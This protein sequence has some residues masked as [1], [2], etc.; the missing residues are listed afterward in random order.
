MCFCMY[1]ACLSAKLRRA[2]TRAV[3][4]TTPRVRCFIK[5]DRLCHENTNHAQMNTRKETVHPGMK[6]KYISSHLQRYIKIVF[7]CESQRFGDMSCRE[8]CLLSDIIETRWHSA[9]AAQSA[10][11]KNLLFSRNHDPVTQDDPQTAL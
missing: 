6:N 8:V 4:N 3:K 2:D 10:P 1:S 5:H 7:S 9:C 11:K